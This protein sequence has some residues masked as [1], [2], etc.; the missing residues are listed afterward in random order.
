MPP[1]AGPPKACKAVANRFRFLA[2]SGSATPELVA[3]A[4]DDS[5]ASTG[6]NR[7]LLHQLE[8]EVR[9]RDFSSWG[10]REPSATAARRWRL[11]PCEHVIRARPAWLVPLRKHKPGPAGPLGTVRRWH[12]PT[13]LATT[14]T[15]PA[16]STRHRRSSS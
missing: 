6:I 4:P 16:R 5:E 3:I 8:A 14:P 15:G 7:G 11:V 13:G 12:G 9:G 10:L 2:Q 1:I